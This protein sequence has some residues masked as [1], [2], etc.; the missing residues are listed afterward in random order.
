[1]PEFK[2]DAYSPKEIADRVENVGITKGNLDFGS[3]LSL[4]L[5]AGAFIG[6]GAL[7]FTLVTTASTLTFGL[8]RLL[9]G[10]VFCLGL[11]LVIV[12]GAELFT[13]NNLI[14]MAY[15]S[16]KTTLTKLLRNWTIAFIGNFIGSLLLVL[17]VA[18]SGHWA[19]NKYLVGANALNIALLKVQ[20]PF[21]E[22]FLKG[23]LCN[24]LVCLAVW[25]CFSCRNVVDKIAAI[26][27]PITAF[28]AL[29]FE[30]SVANMYFIPAGLVLKHMP[31]VVA[32]LTTVLGK[33]PALELL[34]WRTFLFGNLLP[35]TLGNIVGGSYVVGL[36][37]WFVYLRAAAREPVRRLMTH[38]PA[39][40]APGEN[41]A[42]IIKLMKEKGQSSV[43]VGTE[44]AA[45][46]II[47]EADIV[48][49]VLG[50]GRD[51]ARTTAQE[52]MSAPVVAVDVATSLHGIYQEMSARGIR[53]ILI[54]DH[55]REV[56]FVS[57][58]DILRSS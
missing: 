47:S 54:T 30:H 41:V 16:R 32:A 17:I 46:G 43:L 25:L 57:V 15:V 28:V 55:G 26:L 3:T 14:V 35:V 10:L 33:P 27:F 31:P 4:A 34:T 9:G 38:G 1:M 42:A 24:I 22:A 58:K 50:E 23:I 56:G 36:I 51:P 37:Y 48:R 11:I 5:M 7:M 49:K 39:R 29:G 2:M 45:V 21:I 53:H 52:V 40:C 18:F 44:T 8:T 20:I 13:G 12:A 6:F 19:M